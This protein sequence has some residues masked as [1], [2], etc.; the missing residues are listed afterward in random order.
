MILFHSQ[1]QLYLDMTICMERDRQMK[2]DIRVKDKPQAFEKSVTRRDMLK[3]AA[4][5]VGAYSTLTILPESLNAQTGRVVK[6]GRIKQ[7]ICRGCLRRSGMDIEQMAALVSK[8]GMVGIDFICN[9]TMNP[10]I[11]STILSF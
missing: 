4:G 10:L 5:I 1:A 3:S 8:M 9:S 7:A 11:I 2:K 6:K